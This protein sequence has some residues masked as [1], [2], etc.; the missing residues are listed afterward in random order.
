MSELIEDFSKDFRM[1]N[2]KTGVEY[3]E[4]VDLRI[5]DWGK[6]HPAV[7]YTHNCYSE[8]TAKQ[9][10]K[11]LKKYKKLMFV[12]G[13]TGFTMNDIIQSNMRVHMEKLMGDKVNWER[14]EMTSTIFTLVENK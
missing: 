8:N 13:V 5:M 14:G 11:A 6:N 2:E 7:A 12:C 10:V 3:Y 4:K 1:K 9:L